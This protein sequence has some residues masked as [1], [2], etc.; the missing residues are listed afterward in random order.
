MGVGA[1]ILIVS[2]PLVLRK[3]PMNR[4]YGVRL[5]KA[6]VSEDNWYRLN[7]YSGKLLDGFGL[8]EIAFGI[9]SFH[10]MPRNS[11]LEAPL[12][13]A[14]PLLVLIPL[15]GLMNRFAGKLPDR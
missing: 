15:I 3:I 8:F 10:F 9:C 4:Y 12:F 2:I 6:Y 1:L 11:G 14:L 5:P 13:L 7:S